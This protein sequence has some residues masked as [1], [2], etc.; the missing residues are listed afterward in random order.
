M[1]SHPCRSCCRCHDQPAL[2][3]NDRR[4]LHVSEIGHHPP[5]RNIHAGRPHRR[6]GL[7]PEALDDGQDPADYDNGCESLEATMA[8]GV[9]LEFVAAASGD[10]DAASQFFINVTLAS[11]DHQCTVVPDTV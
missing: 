7:H 5:L 2:Q 9:V 1:T 4:Q 11:N 6:Q 3:P 10:H 8:E